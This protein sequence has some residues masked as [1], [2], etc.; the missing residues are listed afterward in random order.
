VNP[1]LVL[2]Y[3]AIRRRARLADKIRRRELALQCIR[4]VDD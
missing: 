1:H 4:F 3:V 2:H